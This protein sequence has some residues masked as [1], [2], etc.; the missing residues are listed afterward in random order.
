[1]KTNKTITIALA[2]IQLAISFSVM[3]VLLLGY[4]SFIGNPNNAGDQL[5][6]N[7]SNSLR[8]AR[9][10]IKESVKTLEKIKGDVPEY[11]NAL[12]LPQTILNQ[13]ATVSYS[14]AD[15]LNFQA[16]SS[17]EMQGMKPIVVMSRP[18][19][20]NAASIKLLG[21][22]IKD[23]SSGVRNAQSTL[24]ELPKLFSELQ[25]TLGSTSEVLDD[26][27]P[28][29]AKLENTVNWGTAIALLFASWCFINSLTTLALAKSTISTSKTE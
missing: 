18:L 8:H 28:V 5:T 20:A 14:L 19:A 17:I 24:V 6:V 4:I 12:Q 29:V 16:P 2:W 11:V 25:S 23:A 21:D 3:A 10:S 15:N 22:Q 26:L 1:M 13:V 7:A 9:E 27:E